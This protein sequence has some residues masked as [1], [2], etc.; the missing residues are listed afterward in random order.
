[1]TMADQIMT[2]RLVVRELALERGRFASFMP[3]P[4]AGM[5]GSGMHLHLSLF[6][7]DINAFHAD[8]AQYSLSETGRMF[9]AGLLRH[10]REI[11]AVTNQ[12]VNSYKR[13]VLGYEAPIW[14]SW[15]QNNRS[16]LVRVPVTRPDKH[17][18]TRIEYRAPDPSCNPYLSFSVILAAG[19]KGIEMGYELPDEVT[20]NLFE[21]DVHQAKRLGVDLLP[22]S[23][24]EALDEMEKSELVHDALGDHIFE[25]F[26]RNK[27]SEWQ[28]YKAH[29]SQWELERYLPSW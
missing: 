4:L 18:S 7:D 20:E 29:V 21:L 6:K 1:M 28:D 23:L 5:Q 24:A 19:M 8:D 22:A 27:R 12:L 15:A 2:F 13:L 11:T 10:A 9:T 16:A 17:S 26:L 14:V 3:K 25:W